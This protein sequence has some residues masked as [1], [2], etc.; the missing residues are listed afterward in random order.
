MRAPSCRLR[1][2]LAIALAA[3]FASGC[4]PGTRAC[5]QGTLFL[6]I[7]FG[8]PTLTADHL[9]I[10]VSIDGGTAKR[11]TRS[12]IDTASNDTVEI[13]FP[14]GYPAGR[15]VDVTVTA[16]VSGTTVGSNTGT[17]A[18][19]P[20]GCAALALVLVGSSP[21]GGGGSGGSGG[22]GGVAGGG[23]AGAGGG[24]AGTGGGSGGTGA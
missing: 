22:A 19:A 13:D 24:T 4:G 21:P 8:G 14:G 20:E 5:K 1:L 3:P 10:E 2:L 12:R 6:T 18:M 9:I 23:A 16:L 11:S 17:V 7:T 15:R